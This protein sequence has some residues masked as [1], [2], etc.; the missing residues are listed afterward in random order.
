MP[1]ADPSL[2]MHTVTSGSLLIFRLGFLIAGD[3]IA[4]ID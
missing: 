1:D 4:R 3:L 2:A